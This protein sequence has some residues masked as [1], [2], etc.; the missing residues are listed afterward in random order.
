M[1]MHSPKLYRNETYD[2]KIEEIQAET[3]GSAEDTEAQGADLSTSIS[4]ASSLTITLKIKKNQD[5]EDLQ[6]RKISPI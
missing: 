3:E 5:K 1:P 4:A 2:L 6:T